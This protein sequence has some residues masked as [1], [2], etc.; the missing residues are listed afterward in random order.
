M[1]DYV[2]KELFVIIKQNFLVLDKCVIVGY[3]MGGYGVLSIVLKNLGMFIL[4]LVFSFIINLVN[5]FWGQKV[6]IVY[7][8][9]DKL[10]WEV[11]DI[12]CLINVSKV[13]MLML[14]DQGLDDNFLVE[15]FKLEVL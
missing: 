2:V 10:V 13:Y 7:L 15:Q 4:V 5:C 3:F 6:F 12:V 8:G 14:V 11:Y 1:Y 9:D